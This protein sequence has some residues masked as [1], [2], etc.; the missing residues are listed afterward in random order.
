MSTKTYMY[1]YQKVGWLNTPSGVRGMEYRIKMKI[2]QAILINQLKTHNRRHTRSLPNNIW[3]NS[4][5][6]DNN[7]EITPR[8]MR[9]A[10][11]YQRQANL[12]SFNYVLSEWGAS[13]FHNRDH[14]FPNSSEIC[15]FCSQN[16]NLRV[17]LLPYAA[18]TKLLCMF[19]TYSFS[20]RCRA[21]TFS[22]YF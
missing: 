15:L 21:E 11:S 7:L 22:L 9:Y 1:E 17:C 13:F 8:G 16:P 6:E 2:T 12:C 14:L 4:N 20:F 10:L 18:H 3:E 19:P 5:F